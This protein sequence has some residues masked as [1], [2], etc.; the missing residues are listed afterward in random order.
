MPGDMSDALTPPG[1]TSMAPFPG[2]S[3]KSAAM[4]LQ[5][6]LALSA[7]ELCIAI[8]VLLLESG[9]AGVR[10]VSHTCVLLSTSGRTQTTVVTCHGP[11]GSFVTPVL[12]VSEGVRTVER[13]VSPSLP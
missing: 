10:S 1:E 8:S 11:S 5:D 3:C 9:R 12:R 6:W 2:A 7:K 13:L 4:L